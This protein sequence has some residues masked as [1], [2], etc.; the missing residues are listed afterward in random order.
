MYLILQNNPGI[1]KWISTRCRRRRGG[2]EEVID[3][4]EDS[5]DFNL[6]FLYRQRETWISQFKRVFLILVETTRGG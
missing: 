2:R 5:S 6:K 3:Y 4:D 1:G